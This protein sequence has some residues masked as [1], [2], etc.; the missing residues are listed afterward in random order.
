M[1][2]VLYVTSANFDSFITYKNGAVVFDFLRMKNWQPRAIDCVEGDVIKWE[3]EA[4]SGTSQVKL[5]SIYT[6]SEDMNPTIANFDDGEI[7]G[8]VTVY[9][10]SDI[11]SVDEYG[12]LNCPYTSYG[13]NAYLEY[14]A[15]SNGL[16][17]FE[18]G[19]NDTS[20]QDFFVTINDILV[21]SNYY[22]I[23]TG[24][25]FYFY[26]TEGDVVRVNVVH[27]SYLDFDNFML[28]S[29]PS[30]SVGSTTILPFQQQYLERYQS[31]FVDNGQQYGWD[32]TPFLN[33]N[34]Y[35]DYDTQSV[36]Y[37]DW[38]FTYTGEPYWG[39]GV[40]GWYEGQYLDMF[41]SYLSFNL[42]PI[43]P[44]KITSAT[45]KFYTIVLR[46]E[47]PFTQ[48]D[49]NFY[50]GY[51][52]S[53]KYHD[54]VYPGI[55]DLR[56]WFTKFDSTYALAGSWSTSELDPDNPNN[57]MSV[58]LDPNNIVI[59]PNGVFMLRAEASN[60]DTYKTP[61]T[62]LPLDYL[63]HIN[64]TMNLY[65]NWVTSH[66][67]AYNTFVLYSGEYYQCVVTHTSGT[68]ATDLAAG[69]WKLISNW[70][71]DTFYVYSKIVE[72]DDKLYVCL[73][74]YYYTS[75]ASFTDDKSAGNWGQVKKW[76]TA[77]SFYVNDIV[78]NETYIKRCTTNHTSTT[79][80]AD[81][82]AGYWVSL[83]TYSFE[84]SQDFEIFLDLHGTENEPTSGV[85]LWL[86]IEYA[87]LTGLASVGSPRR[88]GFKYNGK[89][90]R[91]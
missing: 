74:D 32:R 61:N 42:A 25:Q 48:F 11:W 24:L 7:P 23:Y 43:Y 62:M 66:Y 16:F 12:V 1:F 8:T 71:E 49:L 6:A 80:T 88:A 30:I 63:P 84:E 39:A 38:Y 22:D 87:P 69:K 54:E 4:G 53:H 55:A 36:G 77:T 52:T 45:L 60:M 81:K 86:E 70:S 76:T 83:E 91:Y 18:L 82:A 20:N 85:T 50:S 75:S 59:S 72:N 65:G 35:D 68:F 31:D 78:K 67:F 79:W 58:E 40:R 51:Q 33:T 9:T 34:Y 13:D 15:T 3:F 89:Y 17:Y 28:L 14:T 57:I 41:I 21:F 64:L 27:Q 5:K 90:G 26:V 47:S 2:E 73:A 37:D 19:F 10:D 56:D 29:T 44:C 46:P